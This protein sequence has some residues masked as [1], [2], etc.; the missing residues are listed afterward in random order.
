MLNIMLAGVALLRDI[1]L[2][3]LLGTSPEADA[4]FLAH[5]IPDFFGNNL[6]ALSVGISC[7]PLFTSMYVRK[8]HEEFSRS[9]AGLTLYVWLGCLVIA[10]AGF[11]FRTDIIGFI[12]RG[13]APEIQNMSTNLF[14]I[15]LPIVLIYPLVTIGSSVSNIRNS[16]KI[17]AFAPVLFNLV[18]I[19]GICISFI[20]GASGERASYIVAIS[21]TAGV[22]TMFVL[23]WG[24]IWLRGKL[25]IGA[26]LKFKI[27]GKEIKEFFSIFAPHT[28][29]LLAYQSVLYVERYVAST[30]GEGNISG[31][32]YAFRISQI[33][34]WVF[35][36]AIS[37]FSLPAVSKLREEGRNRELKTGVL[38]FLK[39]TFV[40]VLPMTVLIHTLREPMIT[41]LFRG[42]AFDE[43]SIGITS[44]ILAGYSLAIIGQGIFMIG[45]RLFV[46]LRIMFVPM[47]IVMF[48]SFVNIAAVFS[49]T[50]RLGAPG[51]GYA[52]AL[53]SVCNG[54]LLIGFI[55]KK[56]DLQ[57]NKKAVKA[58]KIVLANL[59]IIV[60]ALGFKT[61]WDMITDK[62]NL[63]IQIGYAGIVTAVCSG[64]YL[65]MLYTLNIYRPKKGIFSNKGGNLAN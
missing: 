42:G 65:A 36:A 3:A 18:F 52:A 31:L 50:R 40:I 15:I 35:I 24:S 14:A 23:I 22:F 61:L 28:A 37:T 34:A 49:F 26:F 29:I 1:G 58:L 17:P 62:G 25:D 7:I 64:I 60:F 12:G 55:C 43:T 5:F 10:I 47:V 59:P 2:A 56:M 33:P 48:S 57:I 20:L 13:M 53:G 45:I 4:F 8:N 51:I 30:L 9:V 27:S 38:K 46:A 16:F 6:L 11:V 44:G 19:I 54:I 32:N 21:V 63:F 41:V 39:L